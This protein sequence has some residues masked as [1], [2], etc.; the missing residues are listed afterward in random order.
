MMKALKK[1]V[2]FQVTYDCH[3]PVVFPPL[4]NLSSTLPQH[5]TLPFS[6]FSSTLP[7]HLMLRIATTATVDIT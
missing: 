1:C 4:Q 7:Y 3:L 2:R 5:F 6:T